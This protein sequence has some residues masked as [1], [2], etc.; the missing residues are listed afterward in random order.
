M[1][2]MSKWH[3]PNKWKKHADLSKESFIKPYL[4]QTS[5]LT[6]NNLWRY[7]SKYPSIFIKP[8]FGLGGTGIMKITR[9][10]NTY[11]LQSGIRKRKFNNR[12]NLSDFIQKVTHY[13]NYIVQ[14]G[15]HLLTIHN[16]PVDFRVLLLKPKEEWRLMGTIGKVAAANRIVTNFHSGGKGL[17]LHRALMATR[18]FTPLQYNQT[19]QKLSSVSLRIANKFSQHYRH[20]RKLGLDFGIDTNRKIWLL[21][22]NTNPGY[23]LF[24]IHH[25][26]ALFKRIERTTQ[27]ITRIQRNI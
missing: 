20:A 7:L 5:I 25:N 18:H 4:P 23:N 15:I 17:T 19:E 24:K 22:A 16:R 21:E 12:M 2:S 11:I 1:S 14:Q 3:F 27:Y 10:G 9:S 6:K 13:R 8:T 26:K